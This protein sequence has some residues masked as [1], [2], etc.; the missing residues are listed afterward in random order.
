MPGIFDGLLGGLA[1]AAV[2]LFN[3]GE[4]R[5]QNEWLKGA[6]EKTWEREDNAVQRR[7]ADMEAAGINP[8]LAAGSPAS[9]SSPIQIGAP[10]LGTNGIDKA[11]LGIAMAKQK[12]DITKTTADTQVSRINA[13]LAMDQR[14]LIR[15][16]EGEIDQRIRALEINNWRNAWDNRLI[17]KS[18]MRSDVRS[19]AT[20]IDQAL[21]GLEKLFTSS[22]AG[23]F[24]SAAK[25]GGGKL[26]EN[27]KA[28][29]G[30]L[31]HTPGRLA[32]PAFNQFNLEQRLLEE[33]KNLKPRGDGR[34]R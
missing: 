1:G 13:D 26:L 17:E 12:A 15:K 28:G 10:Q 7:A 18:G 34:I 23:V 27:V 31:L 3:L 30:G 32:T 29:I 2:D 6:Q 16:Q 22:R 24:M 25:E 14:R 21:N 8:L 33:A 19:Y 20:E 9:S 5:K 11:A 4:Q